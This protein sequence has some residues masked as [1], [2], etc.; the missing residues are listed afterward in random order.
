[1]PKKLTDCVADVKA[2]G[3]SED[4]AWAICVDSTGLS[5]HHKKKVEKAWDEYQKSIFPPKKEDEVEV[6][7]HADPPEM[8]TKCKKN[9]AE[10]GSPMCFQCNLGKAWEEFA[11]EWKPYKE[12]IKDKE[13]SR[14]APKKAK[15]DKKDKP[16]KD[17]K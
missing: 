2:Q 8:C 9:K 4:S 15:V 10:G 14:K 16:W 6:K 3:K 13:E 11:K 1:M 17:K 12:W 5:P 7:Y